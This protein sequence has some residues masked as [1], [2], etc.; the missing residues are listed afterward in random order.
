M[1][2]SPIKRQRQRLK[3]QKK[4]EKNAKKANRVEEDNDEAVAAR[5]LILPEDEE[6]D[7]ENT[8]S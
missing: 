4:R 7:Q 2:D 3:H 5:Y 1:A 8:E 6:Q